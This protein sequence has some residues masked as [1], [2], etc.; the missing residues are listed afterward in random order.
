MPRVG[1][2]A[3]LLMRSSK[4]RG[5]TGK[6]FLVLILVPPVDKVLKGKEA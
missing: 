5:D 4:R 2:G 6:K 1:F 3:H